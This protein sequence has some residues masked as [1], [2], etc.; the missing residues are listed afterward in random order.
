[1]RTPTRVS[2]L[3]TIAFALAGI[4]WF[5]LEITPPGLGFEDT[6]NPAV[7]LGFVRAHPDIYVNAGL[8][9]I[10]MAITLTA[11]PRSQRGAP[12]PWASGRRRPSDSSPRRSSSSTPAFGSGHRAHCSTLAA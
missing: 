12:T 9:L 4:A 3:S 5:A 7:M 6:D 1:V 8:A 11:S 2:G 10:L